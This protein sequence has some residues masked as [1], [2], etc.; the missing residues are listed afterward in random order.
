HGAGD[1]ARVGVEDL[2]DGVEEKVF[3]VF[4]VLVDH[5]DA[6]VR[7][8][9]DVTDRGRVIALAAEQREGDLEELPA[10]KID[11]L[12][13]AHAGAASLHGWPPTLIER[14]FTI[15]AAGTTR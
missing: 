2:H 5:A 8:A 13:V 12:G 1:F 9:G 7:F 11:A 6:D 3:L 10:S 4:E 14:S 15:I